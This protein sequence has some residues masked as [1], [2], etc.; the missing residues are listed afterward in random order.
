M[1]A[2]ELKRKKGAL[3]RVLIVLGLQPTAEDIEHKNEPIEPSDEEQTVDR[4]GNPIP[5]K[6]KKV[7]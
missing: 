6:K 4:N 2:A 7:E 5:K 1:D 3:E